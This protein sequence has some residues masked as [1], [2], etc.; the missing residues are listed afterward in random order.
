[1]DIYFLESIA[2]KPAS[3]VI[4]TATHTIT[5]TTLVVLEGHLIFTDKQETDDEICL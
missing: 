2:A 4:P 3:T 5:P 1:M